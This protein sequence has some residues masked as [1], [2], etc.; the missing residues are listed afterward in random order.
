MKKSFIS[1]VVVGSSLL[2][3]FGLGIVAEAGQ[4]YT[5]YSTTVGRLNGSGYTSYQTKSVSGQKADVYLANNGGYKVDV[6]TNSRDGSSG[7]WSR[8]L[9]A[10]SR[11]QLTNG[12]NKGSKVRLH[13]SN[14]IT[15]RVNTQAQGN[16]R[17]N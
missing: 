1:K 14:N 16:W 9:T 11:R 8:G 5:N 7:E 13:F 12:H 2:G 6:R 10:G 17:S 4:T 3:A 15:T